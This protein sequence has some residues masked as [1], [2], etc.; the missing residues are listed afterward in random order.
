MAAIYSNIVCK[1]V[2]W[3]DGLVTREDRE[4]L[5]GH[6]GAAVWFTGLSASGKSTIAHH[7]E[8]LLHDKNMRYEM[9]KRG[10]TI[11]RNFSEEKMIEKIDALYTSLVKYLD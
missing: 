9:G 2:T 7:L 5:H 6:K 3:H 4:K 10:Q 11:A 8:K 1:N